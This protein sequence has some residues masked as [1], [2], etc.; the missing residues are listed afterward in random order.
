MKTKTL[1]RT[2]LSKMDDWMRVNARAYDLAKWDHLFHSGTKDAIVHEMLNYQNPD[3][4]FGHGF[5]ADLLSPLSAAI[6]TAEAIFQAYEYGLD[7]N[8]DWMKRALSYFEN[9]LLPI[10]KYWEDCPR[11]VLNDP[12]AP[13]WK[14]IPATAFSPNPCAVVASAFLRFGTDRQKKLGE[15]IAKDCF[16]LLL[17][18]GFCG[19]H[20]TL[21]LQALVEQLSLM[22]S[23]LITQEIIEAMQR[24]ILENTCFDTGKYHKYYFTPADFVSSPDSMWYGVVGHGMEQMLDYWLDTLNEQD[25][26]TPN[27]SWG[28]DTEAAKR[29]TQ[30]WTGYLAVKRARILKNFNRIE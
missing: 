22:H 18:N 27:F 17:G 2:Q 14:A 15:Q 12:H 20:D 25:V 6:P 1:S 4:G 13:W 21:N 11:E 16:R 8:A 5:E 19:D 30:C 29:S 10:P 23:P 9:T 3:G 24:R 26:W 7:C 28:C